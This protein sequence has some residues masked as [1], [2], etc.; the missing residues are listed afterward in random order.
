MAN[1]RLLC[2]KI[3]L[4]LDHCEVS[5]CSRR[6]RGAHTP[7]EQVSDTKMPRNIHPSPSKLVCAEEKRQR[8]DVSEETNHEYDLASAEGFVVESSAPE[9]ETRRI[10]VLRNKR[11]RRS[12]VHQK[13]LKDRKID[14]AN[15]WRGVPGGGRG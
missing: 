13:H 4:P 5:R 9:H 11:Y 1:N 3:A 15:R 8:M 6:L 14:V 2:E 10:P 7:E 12:S